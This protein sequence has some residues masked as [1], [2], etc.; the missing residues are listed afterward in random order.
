MREGN[1]GL[2]QRFREGLV[3]GEP[4]MREI[5]AEVAERH[6]VDLNAMLRARGWSFLTR[7]RFEAMTAIYDTGRFSNLQ[8]ARLFNLTDHTGT[9]HARRRAAELR[10]GEGR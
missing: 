4:T 10:A 7:A 3:S 2:H 6:G 8:V 5:A 1:P 9:V